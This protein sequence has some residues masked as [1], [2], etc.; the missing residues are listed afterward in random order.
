[1]AHRP[2][3]PSATVLSA[4]RCAAAGPTPCGAQRERPLPGT[5]RHAGVQRRAR[6]L[7]PW[8]RQHTLPY[9]TLPHSTQHAG[10]R[11]A[12]HPRSPASCT[13]RPAARPC[14]RA[15]PAPG[16]RPR[17]PRR[18]PASPAARPGRRAAPRPQA[19]PARAP[20]HVAHT[21]CASEP[22][23]TPLGLHAW[24]QPGSARS[25]KDRHPP[26]RI[27]IMCVDR[28]LLAAH[29]RCECCPFISYT[30]C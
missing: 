22:R 7:E 15:R 6:C 5:C 29:R 30:P 26:H 9:P 24:P 27:P 10:G 1:M 23:R 28:M 8:P 18:P 13:C 20:R 4:L 19:L 3:P 12:A 11:P 16:A 25:C 17:L 21:G 2:S 14:A